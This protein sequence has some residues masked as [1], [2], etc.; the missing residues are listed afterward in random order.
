[1]PILW[2]SFIQQTQRELSTDFSVFINEVDIIVINEVDIIEVYWKNNQIQ[3]YG[4]E[5]K[6]EINENNVLC[7][8]KRRKGECDQLAIAMVL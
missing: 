2:K 7:R 3:A 4:K 6:E 5:G 8:I 1:M